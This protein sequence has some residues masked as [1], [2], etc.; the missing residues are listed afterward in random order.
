VPK[1]QERPNQPRAPPGLT[2]KVVEVGVDQAVSLRELRPA[3]LGATHTV[4]VSAG[5]ATDDDPVTSRAHPVPSLQERDDRPIPSPQ[6]P[7]VATEIRL[8]QAV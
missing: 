7:G 6:F 2:G 3:I 5:V 1:L 8:D 4:R